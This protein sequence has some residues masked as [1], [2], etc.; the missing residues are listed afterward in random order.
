MWVPVPLDRT[1]MIIKWKLSLI[2]LN[3]ATLIT[4]DMT[5]IFPKGMMR[6][7]SAS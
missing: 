6:T 7:Q 4:L 5:V 2:P 3:N 1:A